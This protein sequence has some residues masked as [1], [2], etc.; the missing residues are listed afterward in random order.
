M[1]KSACNVMNKSIM[2]SVIFLSVGILLEIIAQFLSFES[3]VPALFTYIGFFAIFLG[4]SIIT[5][6]II[7]ILIPK[8]NHYLDSCQH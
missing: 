4:L 7:A 3:M 6:T 2:I 5:G 1:G 8:V